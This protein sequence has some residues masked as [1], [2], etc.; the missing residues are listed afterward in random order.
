MKKRSQAEVGWS[1]IGLMTISRDRL[2]YVCMHGSH[3]RFVSQSVPGRRRSSRDGTGEGPSSWLWRRKKQ[4]QHV[5][6]KR[7]S[8]ASDVAAYVVYRNRP[9]VCRRARHNSSA[10][11][12]CSLA[13]TSQNS[14]STKQDERFRPPSPFPPHRHLLPPCRKGSRHRTSPPCDDHRRGNETGHPDPR[15]KLHEEQGRTGIPCS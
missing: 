14:E 13:L 11:A 8:K 3:A 5:K 12:L 2:V 6:S 10:R 15:S 1:H 9:S 4:V 7:A